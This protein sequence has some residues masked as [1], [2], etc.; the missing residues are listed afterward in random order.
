MISFEEA[1]RIVHDACNEASF[2]PPRDGDTIV[3]WATTALD[4]ALAPKGSERW[5]RGHETLMRALNA[6]LIG[7]KHECL[8]AVKMARRLITELGSQACVCPQPFPQVIHDH[9]SREFCSRCH[10]RR[11]NP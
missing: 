10:L 4:G 7:D 6:A 5:Q 11:R 1:T 3:D 8:A 9:L 2:T